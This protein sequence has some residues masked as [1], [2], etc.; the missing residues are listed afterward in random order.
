MKNLLNTLRK[1][2]RRQTRASLPQLRMR[3][4]PSAPP[5]VEAL[6]PPY[7]LRRFREGD[8]GGWVA[9]LNGRGEL[10]NWTLQRLSAEITSFLV[11]DTQYFVLCDREIVSGA[12]VYERSSSCWEIGWVATS[13]DHRGRG[14]ARHVCI[15]AA[16]AAL[17]LPSRPIWLFTDDFRTL[18]IKLYLRLGFL[19][20]C[21]H[22]S[23]AVRWRTVF[24]QLGPEYAKYGGSSI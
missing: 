2:W 6:G 4:A 16:A 3:F 9:L 13:P 12:G 11:A 20:D 5:P 23:H 19:P 7:S 17:E 15:A 22:H 21:H 18:A 1:R 10:G 14:L 24:E 8:E